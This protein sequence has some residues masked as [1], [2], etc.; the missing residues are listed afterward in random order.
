MIILKKQLWHGI[1]IEDILFLRKKMFFYPFKDLIFDFIKIIETFLYLYRVIVYLC[2]LLFI[3]NKAIIIIIIFLFAFTNLNAQF[4][5]LLNNGD[6]ENYTI[7]PTVGAQ[8]NRATG[9]NNVNGYYGIS[10]NGSPDYFYFGANNA[11]INQFG[12]M[13]PYSGNGQMG[14]CIFCCCSCNIREYISTHLNST[15]LIGKKYTVSFYLSNG[16]GSFGNLV[17]CN[18]YGVHFST[19]P[20]YQSFCEQ[21]S[22]VP[23][24]EITSI[25]SA[26][27]VWKHFAFKYIPDSSYNIVT[28]GNF[29]NDSL[30]LFTPNLGYGEPYYFIDKIEIFPELKITGDSIICKGSIST[31]K[32]ISGEHIVKWVDSLNQSTIIAIDSSIT[33]TPNV[34]TTYV[35]ISTSD[36]A[37]FT[38]HV[39]APIIN[40]GND[41]SLCQGQSLLLNAYNLNS[42]YLWQ[43]SS[44]NATYNVF[45]A[46]CYYVKVTDSNYCISYDTINITYNPLPIVNLG[47]DTT[48]CLGQ[49]LIL[50]GT[51]PYSTY[52][53]QDNSVNPIY[54]VTQQGIY[55]VIVIDNNNCSANDT[56]NISYQDCSNPINIPN[57]FTPNGDGLND[58]FKI[59][60]L[61]E[62]SEFNMYIYNR[63]GELLFES[64]D[65]N[66]GWDGTFK[67]KYVPYG[68]YVYLLT[69]TIKDTNEQ[70]KRNGTVTV[71]R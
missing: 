20:L 9:W 23:Q 68:V 25:I 36:T 48:L 61:K 41:T 4:S 69:G 66:K 30:T 28:F 3:M 5:N 37:Y 18:N 44:I 57:S 62:F 12:A 40:L 1:C 35:A 11:S 47:N 65:K 56:I 6:F 8:C 27:G 38:V 24:L 67:G 10:G 17:Y 59:V 22:V 33:V 70:I 43:D 34:T 60:T 52:I 53:W 13:T 71:L 19:M 26:N 31:I 63:W 32:V 49:T 58:E 21:I 29:R 15:M 64:T 7:P 50:N 42:T 46:G 2:Y 39:N 16:I 45:Q 14:Q 54:N 51:N 55:W